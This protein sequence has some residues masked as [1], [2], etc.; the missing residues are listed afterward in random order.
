MKNANIFDRQVFD[1]VQYGLFREAF[2]TQIYEIMYPGSTNGFQLES[3]FPLLFMARNSQCLRPH[4]P[5]IR[6]ISCDKLVVRAFFDDPAIMEY[7]NQVGLLN[8]G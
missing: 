7:D 1:A 4:H 3:L 5:R 2:T 6:A 8:G